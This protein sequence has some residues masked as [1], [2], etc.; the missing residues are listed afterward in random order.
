ML[1][2]L[3][4]GGAAYAGAKALRRHQRQNRCGRFLRP[5][6][7][8]KKLDNRL[9]PSFG[10][11]RQQQLR[12]IASNVD[13]QTRQVAQQQVNMNMTIA[14]VSL[15]LATV[16]SLGFPVLSLLSLPGF[17]YVSSHVAVASYHAVV[18]QRKVSIDVLSLLVK[19]LL[20]VYGQFLLCNVSTFIYA[21]SRKLLTVIKDQSRKQLIDVFRQQPRYAWVLLDGVELERPYETLEL[22]DIVVVHAGET[23]S[24]D[25]TITAGHATIDQHML[26]GEAQPVEKEV[27]EAVFALTTVLAGRICIRVEKAGETTA[28][29]QIGQILNRT[30]D[31]KTDLQFWVE[32][33]SD[34]TV[35]PTLLLGACAWPFSGFMSTTAILYSHPRHKTTIAGAIDILNFLNT[36]SRHGILLKDGRTFEWLNQVDTVVFDKTGTLTVGQPHVGRIHPCQGYDEDQVICFAAAAETNQHHPIARAIRQAAQERA[37]EV[38][39]IDEASYVVGYGMTVMVGYRLVQV[40]S[41]RFMEMEEIDV[42]AFIKDTQTACH[43]D[44]HSLVLVAL[45]SEIIGAIELRPTVRPEAKAVIQMLRQQGITSMYIISGDHEI[46]TRKLAEALG[47][48]HYFAETLPERKAD[49]IE[50]LQQQG[51]AVC[52]VGDGINDAIALKKA[53]VSISLRGA[54]TV[55]TD[56]AQVILMDQSLHRLGD[57]FVLAR[58]Y[59]THIKRTFLAVL[60]P[61]LVGMGGALFFQFGFVQAVILAQLGMFAGLVHAMRPLPHQNH[62]LEVAMDDDHPQLLPGDTLMPGE[63]DLPRSRRW[64]VAAACDG[65][66]EKAKPTLR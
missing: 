18:K 32:S 54:S 10:S 19:A 61:H 59:Q 14:S 30:V 38:P 36:A 63:D 50:Q 43:A 55:A 52:Y 20:F 8:T 56:A 7:V 24:V 35:M 28:A 60:T 26:T 53:T 65:H 58:Q 39:A 4:I 27:G 45:D 2:E 49:L 22:D 48:E 47:I 37:V 57:L 3:A 40:G 29:A 42:P 34:K 46:P 64:D 17:F 21:F 66:P 44:G 6:H 15:G 11:G 13:D 33:M 25:G 12:S 9:L 23:I 41:A 5:E 16:G 1:Y 51:K 62:S 31:G